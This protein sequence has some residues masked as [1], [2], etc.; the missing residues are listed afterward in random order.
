MLR[1]ELIFRNLLLMQR[2]RISESHYFL[3]VVG[4]LNRNGLSIF[5]NT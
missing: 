4:K 5:A 2:L 3:A 1:K